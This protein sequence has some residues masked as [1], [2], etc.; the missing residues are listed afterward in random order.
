M[1]R[2]VRIAAAGDVHASEA[3]R[4]R[5]E[6]AFAEVD[7]DADLILLAG[8]LTTH[9]EP[10]QALVLADACRDLRTP[11]CAVLGNHDLH[12]GHGDE[13]A[14][15]CS[16]AGIHMLDRLSTVCEFAGGEVGTEPKTPLPVVIGDL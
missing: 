9:G 14:A 11:V 7:E 2:M 13:V 15:V 3:T 10:D 5:I 12:S 4:G 8:D 1:G 6:E 16:D